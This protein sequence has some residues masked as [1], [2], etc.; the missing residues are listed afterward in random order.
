MVVPH[1]E[2]CCTPYI[3]SLPSKK[4]RKMEAEERDAG[5]GGLYVMEG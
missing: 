1:G 5:T 3:S 2:K 4:I